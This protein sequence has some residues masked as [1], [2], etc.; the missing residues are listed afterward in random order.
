[1]DFEIDNLKFLTLYVESFGIFIA[2]FV[3]SHLLRM[4][5]Y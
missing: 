4:I 3:A 5:R 1:M 2:V